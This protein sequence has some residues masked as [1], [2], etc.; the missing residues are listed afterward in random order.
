MK[1][2]IAAAAAVGMLVTGIATTAVPAA[3]ATKTLTLGVLQDVPGWDPQ[4]QG[5]GNAS[6][7]WQAV[8]DTLFQLDAKGNVLPNIATKYAYD[9]TF[10]K[11]TLTIRPGVKFT[12]G[13]ALDAAAVATNL[14]HTKQGTGEAGAFLAQLTGAK[15]TSKTTVV[16]SLKQPDPGLLLQLAL[17]SGTLASP[18]AIAAGTSNTT[19]VGSGPYVLDSANTVKGSRYTFA[20]NAKYWNKSEYPADTVVLKVMSGLT[21]MVNAMAAGEIDAGNVNDV[22]QVPPLIAKGLDVMQFGTSDV[23]GLYLFDHAGTTFKPISDVR[24]RQAMNHAIDRTTIVAKAY[25]GVGSPTA[26]VFARGGSAYVPALDS[27]YKYDPAKAKSLL[28]DAGY[29]DGFDLPLPDVRAS[30]PAA[31]AALQEYFAAVGIKIQWKA[32]PALAQYL[33]DIQAGKYPVVYMPLNSGAPFTTVSKEVETTG[34][35]NMFKYQDAGMNALLK[36][37]RTTTGAAQTAAL[38]EINTKMVKD[39]WNVP[40]IQV[41]N[42]F[43]F[44]KNLRVKFAP[45]AALPPLRWID[46]K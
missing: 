5:N 46:V 35:W 17:Q 38:K 29:P 41:V 6:P 26:Q 21:A 31:A 34:T 14:M 39:A 13:T 11:L 16:V 18:K 3:A 30:F 40:V 44:T 12:D 45:Y 32:R 1:K 27:Y 19:P 42:Q 43:V 36:K 22:K 8:Y 37:A 2:L 15:A 28:K 9:K 33:A 20:R 7:F 4:N 25:Y 23:A 24:V 10:T